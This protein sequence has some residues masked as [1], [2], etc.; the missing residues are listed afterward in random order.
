MYIQYI[1]SIR[2]KSTL[3]CVWVSKG[4]KEYLLFIYC[5]HKV[6][7]LIIFWQFNGWFM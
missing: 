7:I 1:Q 6:Y 2:I 5:T 4:F 3:V